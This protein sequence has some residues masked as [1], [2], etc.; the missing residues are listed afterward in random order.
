MCLFVWPYW[1][2]SDENLIY[3]FKDDPYW[4]VRKVVVDKLYDEKF[5]FENFKDD[6]D[7]NVRHRVVKKLS[8]PQLAFDLFKDDTEFSDALAELSNESLNLP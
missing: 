8:N 2:D 7:S 5:I 1:I 6:P 3:A 4:E